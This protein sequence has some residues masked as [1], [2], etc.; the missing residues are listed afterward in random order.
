MSIK[1]S[2]SNIDPYRRLNVKVGTIMEFGNAYYRI[3]ELNP[4][5]VIGTLIKQRD[6]S[7][8]ALNEVA[9][10][11]AWMKYNDFEILNEEENPEYWL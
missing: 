7:E 4:G 6:D 9:I 10:T 5:G 2:K 1:K 3:V 8:L 11:Y